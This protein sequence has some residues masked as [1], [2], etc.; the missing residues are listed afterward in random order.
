M[1]RKRTRGR[2]CPGAWRGGILRA[3][4]PLPTAVALFHRLSLLLLLG[5]PMAAAQTAEPP[6]AMCE[7]LDPG[8]LPESPQDKLILTADSLNL[9]REGLSDLA[10]SVRLR[11]G[12]R[13]FASEALQYDDVNRRVLASKPSRFR[14][15]AYLINAESA[16]FDLNTEVGVF[17]RAQFTL[18][19]RGARGAA[20]RV[21]LSREGQAEL[22]NVYYTSCSPRDESWKITAEKLDLDRDE[23]LGTARNATIRF[24]DVPVIYVPYMQFPIDDR[25]RTG[26]LFPS[27]GSDTRTGVDFSWPVYLNLHPQYDAIFTP[28]FMSD[29]GTQLG[30]AGRYLLP[31]GTG[32]AKFEY[33]ADDQQYGTSR[34]LSEFHHEGL[35]NSRLSLDVNYA[36]VSDPNYFE[37]LSRAIDFSSL[38]HLERSARLIYQA[39]GAYTLQ[40]LVQDF[41]PLASRLTGIDDPYQRLPELRFDA[42]TRNDFYNTRLGINAQLVNFAR[43]NSVEGLRQSLQPYVRYSRDGGGYFGR[44]Q[45]D[46]NHT[47]YQLTNN[48]SG[49]N[50]P[51]RTLPLFSADTGLRF[52]KFGNG[53]DSMQVLEPRLFYLYVPFREQSGLPVFDTDESDYDVPQLFARNRFSGLDRIADANQLTTALTWRILDADSGATRV[54]AT[55]GQIYRFTESRVTLPGLDAP[56][57]GSSDYLGGLELRLNSKLSATSTLQWSPDLGDFTRTG[58]ALRYRDERLR[59]DLAYRYRKDLLEQTDAALSLPI[60]GSWRLAGRLRRS[61]RDERTLD[62]LLGVEYETCCWALRSSYRRYLI[63]SAGDT[64]SG[65]FLQIELK[66]LSRFGSGF[67]ELLPGDDRPLGGY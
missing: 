35:L 56:D 23:G 32:R 46:L 39:P 28:R 6:P 65:V 58:L 43:P 36:E 55:F 54:A 67:D 44:V 13:E 20:R 2:R 22:D 15:S 18:T 3:L 26:L 19:E 52:I 11:L 10:G 30:L 41:Q 57:P 59:G 42:I 49:G 7:Q 62:A 27:L 45:L 53:G 60:G 61:L 17:E 66:G 40:A 5:L 8:A 51:E 29:R 37:D 47:R 31:R 9:E 14:N 1:A 50:S 63:N 4:S 25:R 24:G 21:E 12:E 48:G 34:G 33:L 64:S 38:T 16:S